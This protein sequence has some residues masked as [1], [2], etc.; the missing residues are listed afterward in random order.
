MSPF[1]IGGG[2]T[3]PF[4]QLPSASWLKNPKRQQTWCSHLVISLHIKNCI[5]CRQGEEHWHRRGDVCV[6]EKDPCETRAALVQPYLMGSST[7]H[8]F[9]LFCF[10]FHVCKPLL[11]AEV[12]N[13]Y[14][15]SAANYFTKWLEV[16]P[17]RRQESLRIIKFL[18]RSDS[19][20]Q[21][22]FWTY[23]YSVGLRG[24]G[25]PPTP[26]SHGMGEEFIGAWLL[27]QWSTM[28]LGPGISHFFSLVTGCSWL[29]PPC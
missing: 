29:F 18:T 19:H 17:G 13:Q 8:G 26:A 20:L 2:L 23:S 4:L 9:A 6:I 22:W 5:K 27:S 11:E 3:S 12:D 25:S 24:I 7:D 14:L 21:R 15:L 28:P 10:G 16:S 1:K